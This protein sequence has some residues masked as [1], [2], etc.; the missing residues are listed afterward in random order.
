MTSAADTASGAL[1]DVAAFTRGPTNDI[2]LCNPFTETKHT[3]HHE[4]VFG[5]AS[6]EKSKDSKGYNEVD[7]AERGEVSNDGNN[8]VRKGGRSVFVLAQ[9]D[10]QADTFLDMSHYDLAVSRHL[11]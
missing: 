10:S 7:D 11:Y 3:T 4:E 6:K 2:K 5:T 9:I 1:L 8:E